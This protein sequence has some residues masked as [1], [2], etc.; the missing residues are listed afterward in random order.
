MLAKVASV[1]LKYGI[2]VAK[3]HLPCTEN[4]QEEGNVRMN[5]AALNGLNYQ[6]ENNK[7]K[8]E[9]EHENSPV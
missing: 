2:S 4:N 9:R 8:L 5:S 3:W 6:S 7:K 1:D